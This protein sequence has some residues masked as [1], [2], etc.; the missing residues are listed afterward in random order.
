MKQTVSDIYSKV[1][2]FLVRAAVWYSQGKLRHAWEALS[3]PVEL[4][5]DD[6]IQDIVDCAKSVDMLANAGAQAEQ[7]DMHLE[8]QSLN[9]AVRELR[10]I[11]ICM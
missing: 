3:R 4:Y 8:L 5:Y 1:M 7:R 2:I 6:L 9:E 10:G 11:L